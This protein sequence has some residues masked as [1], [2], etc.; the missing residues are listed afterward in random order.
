[1]GVLGQF[2]YISVQDGLEFE[3]PEIPLHIEFFLF[4]NMSACRSLQPAH[5]IL[6]RKKA[7]KM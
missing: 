2:M 6:F 1:M 7:L 5:F 3:E 4:K